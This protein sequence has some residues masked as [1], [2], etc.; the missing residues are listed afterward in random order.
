MAGTWDFKLAVEDIENQI[1]RINATRSDDATNPPTTVSVALS[2]DISTPE[3]K[4]AALDRLW[5]KYET[6][7]TK[8]AAI[9]NVL[10]TLE[11]AAKAN[12]EARE[13]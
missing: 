3:L 2:A 11:A 13:A 1:V 10:G 5:A 8:A 9:K 12:F 6:I 4:L 7:T